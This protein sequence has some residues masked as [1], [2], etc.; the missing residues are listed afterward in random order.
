[1]IQSLRLDTIKT[2]KDVERIEDENVSYILS[3]ADERANFIRKLDTSRDVVLV[4]GG[5]TLDT[6]VTREMVKNKFGNE[7]SD[8]FYIV[9]I[10]DKWI[11]CDDYDFSFCVD[12]SAILHY[13]T[14]NTTGK[15]MLTGPYAYRFDQNT[16]GALAG[17]P[18]NVF[19]KQNA[20]LLCLCSNAQSYKMREYAYK[21]TNEMNLLNIDI[22]NGGS[23][24]L[25]L[26]SKL[27]FKN[28][29]MI[30]FGGTGYTNLCS[31]I[32][33]SNRNK[34]CIGNYPLDLIR[35]AEG[36]TMFR[37]ETRCCEKIMGII[38][39]NAH[40]LRVFD[41]YSALPDHTV[42]VF[43]VSGTVTDLDEYEPMGNIAADVSYK[44]TCVT[45]VAASLYDDIASRDNLNISFR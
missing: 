40:S 43:I 9:P 21:R 22:F 33:I 36:E 26:M 15:Y 39:K 4:G 23:M 16:H 8:D 34:Y 10:N 3:E 12:E 29:K 17:I 44:Y 19:K 45:S 30:G 1:M 24:A 6:V 14:Y 5:P 31:T 32:P 18:Y 11:F 35:L 13:M 7:L 42:F 38:E 41:R 25:N 20:G 37:I 28:I 2:E 27:N